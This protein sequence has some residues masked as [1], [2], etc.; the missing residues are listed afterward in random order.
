MHFFYIFEL[1]FFKVDTLQSAIEYIKALE[2]LVRTRRSKA[3]QER[4]KQEQSEARDQEQ[5]QDSNKPQE[6]QKPSS[7]SNNFDQDAQN[8]DVIFVGELTDKEASNKDKLIGLTST[9]PTTKSSSKKPQRPT[10]LTESMLKAFDV[11][12]QKCANERK[13]P[14]SKVGAV[15]GSEVGEKAGAEH[16]A[17]EN[18]QVFRE[19]AADVSPF[20]MQSQSSDSGFSEM[21]NDGF[22][23][24]Q[25]CQEVQESP[26][27]DHLTL[28][29][30]SQSPCFGD[31][32]PDFQQSSPILEAFTSPGLQEGFSPIGEHLP[33]GGFL[34]A[35]GDANDCSSFV[36]DQQPSNGIRFASKQLQWDE[37]DK[38]QE[39]VRCNSA[40]TAS[41]HSSVSAENVED[42]NFVEVNTW[43]GQLHSLLDNTFNL[44]DTEVLDELDQIN[45]TFDFLPSSGAYSFGH[46]QPFDSQLL[47][48]PVHQQTYDYVPSVPA[49]AYS[50]Q[51]GNMAVAA[52]WWSMYA[53]HYPARFFV[54]KITIICCEKYP[55]VSN[56]ASVNI[57]NIFLQCTNC[58]FYCRN[59]HVFSLV[60]FSM[61]NA[62]FNVTSD[63]LPS[64]V[65]HNMRYI[66]IQSLPVPAVLYCLVE[67]L[68]SSKYSANHYRSYY[69]LRLF[70]FFS[71]KQ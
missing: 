1:V 14:C 70:C 28:E 44:H 26:R 54:S 2:E 6:Q 36:P 5:K 69:L 39:A 68:C 51:L 34:S 61:H 13:T 57:V 33:H 15:T 32:M 21:L 43:N 62:I 64:S 37:Q 58:I 18:E 49:L 40:S 23:L 60:L 56:R 55:S 65:L 9:L 48:P 47:S 59:R 11:M 66:K 16:H 24:E 53:L 42:K 52:L 19:Y 3:A 63:V 31:C 50:E 12:L 29:L 22:D 20:E 25:S 71:P 38:S 67:L 27:P 7:N 8:E 35:L 17:Q 4:N 41:S 45:P 30:A 46:N 10:E